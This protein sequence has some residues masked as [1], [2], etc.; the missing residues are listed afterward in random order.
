MKRRSTNKR[1]KLKRAAWAMTLMGTFLT[2]ACFTRIDTDPYF[3]QTYY[4]RSME[5]LRGVDAD[6]DLTPKK[7]LAG[8]ARISITPK[9]DGARTPLSDLPLAGYGARKGAPAL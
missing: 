7:I 6:P 8:A 9:L 1:S 3:T 2:F 5:S 4:A